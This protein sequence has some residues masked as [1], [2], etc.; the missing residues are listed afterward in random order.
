MFCKAHGG[1]KRCQYP[2][3]CDKSAKGSTMFCIAHGGG[4]R[5][6]HESGCRKHVIRGGL[7]KSHGAEAGV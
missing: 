3:G 4:R 1:G 2:E 5:C 7:C 6:G